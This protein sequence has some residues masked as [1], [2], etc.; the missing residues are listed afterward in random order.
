MAQN[1]EKTCAK[2]GVT[3]GKQTVADSAQEAPNAFTGRITGTGRKRTARLFLV[4]EFVFVK[5]VDGAKRTLPPVCDSRISRMLVGF[6]LHGLS[7][8]QNDRVRA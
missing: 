8:V 7:H 2:H 6:C 4:E 3:R 1:A 5:A